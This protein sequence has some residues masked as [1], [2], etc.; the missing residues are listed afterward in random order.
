MLVLGIFLFLVLAALGCIVYEVV[1]AHG[2]LST[3][4]ADAKAD[5][6]KAEATVESLVTDAKKAV[7]R[8]P[9]GPSR[10]VR[11]IPSS[12]LIH[13]PTGLDTAHKQCKNSGNVQKKEDN[14]AE[15]SVRCH[16]NSVPELDGER[17]S[18]ER[19]NG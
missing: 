14:R 10:R 5:L 11:P 13:R 18:E 12:W 1:K 3:A 9:G 15:R 17:V 6:A 19:K 8:V 2:N 7:L 16:W 4:L